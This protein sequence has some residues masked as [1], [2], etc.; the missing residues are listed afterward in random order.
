[1]RISMY[2]AVES[3][4]RARYSEHAQASEEFLNE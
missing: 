3:Q 2:A 4:T 1:M